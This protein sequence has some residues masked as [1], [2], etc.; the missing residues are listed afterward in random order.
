MIIEN[1]ST[2]HPDN[3][4]IFCHSSDM[5]MNDN[6]QR[7]YSTFGR[8]NYDPPK[9]NINKYTVV[10]INN[11]LLQQAF[12]SYFPV[13]MQENNISNKNTTIKTATDK[14]NFKEHK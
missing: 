10:I 2:Y 4:R 13:V 5:S 3:L 14:R 1:L 12:P 6:K 11:S 9:I 8:N 7:I